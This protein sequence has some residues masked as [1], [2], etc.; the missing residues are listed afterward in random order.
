MIGG[1]RSSIRG[2]KTCV[3][4]RRKCKKK[5]KPV[6]L[7]PDVGIR[8][9]KVWVHGGASKA[10]HGEGPGLGRSGDRPA[11]GDTGG[12]YTWLMWTEGP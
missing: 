10:P 2:F 8:A 9:N 3:L 1:E 5:N 6:D 12:A 11:W 7:P 4:G